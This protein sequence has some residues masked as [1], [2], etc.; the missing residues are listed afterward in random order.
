MIELLAALALAPWTHPL[1][2]R[3]LPGWHTGASGTVRSLYDNASRRVPAPKESA[4]WVATSVRYRDRATEDPPNRTLAHLRRD[5]VIV[6]AVIFQA[7]KVGRK[8]IRLDL[9]RARHLAC[10]EG[11]YV[12][13]G[14]DELAGVGPGG[15]YS[16]L[17]RVY[18]GSR[19]TMARRATAQRALDHL[20]LPGRTYSVLVG[21]GLRH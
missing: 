11:E 19:P 1:A 17:V 7:G 3:P 13:G 8:P 10:C 14:L 4:A 18:F 21:Q 6:W 5:A 20:A 9:R 15:A 12:P 16:V 2:F